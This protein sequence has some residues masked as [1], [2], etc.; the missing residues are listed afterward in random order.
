M[1]GLDLVS[2]S[3]LL[4]GVL[5][6]GETPSGAESSDGLGFLNDLLDSWNAERL[7]VYTI[8]REASDSN[9]NPFYLTLGKQDYTMG[10]AGNFNF[11][12]PARIERAG[13][14]NLANP[15]MPLELPLEYLTD[16]Q[17]ADIPVKAISSALPTKVY[18]DQGFP[19]RTLSYWPIPNAPVAAVFY[20][21]NPLSQFPDLST[22]IT[23]PPGYARALRYNLA[24][25][26]APGYGRQV[27]PVVAAI[28]TQSKAVVKS[29]NIPVVDLKVDP[30]IWG[31]TGQGVYNWLSDTF[32]RGTS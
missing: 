32:G 25:E 12:R 14:F 29:L 17:W 27:D 21:W 31:R 22:D 7:M 11:P 3:L 13:I 28:A 6:S 23:F 9:G 10:T 15:A 26:M 4:A 16:R 5:A 1:T 2:R 19:L 20:I 24:V 18:D 8:A 30:A